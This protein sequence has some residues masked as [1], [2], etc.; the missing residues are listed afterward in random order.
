MFINVSRRRLLPAATGVTGN[1]HSKAGV[2][3]DDAWAYLINSK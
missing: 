3:N 2:A 1:T